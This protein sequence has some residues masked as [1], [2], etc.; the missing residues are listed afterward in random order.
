ML[1]EVY[2]Y[3]FPDFVFARISLLYLALREEE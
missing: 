3:G 1:R 2:D